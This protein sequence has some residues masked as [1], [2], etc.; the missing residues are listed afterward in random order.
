MSKH[1]QCSELHCQSLICRFQ[2]AGLL[3]PASALPG[4][5]FRP[6]RILLFIFLMVSASSLAHAANCAL[7]AGA[8]T[9]RVQAAVRAAA[10]DACT[11]TASE[12]TV[13][14]GEGSYSLKQIYVP[15][16]RSHLIFTGPVTK[17]PADSNARPTAVI[18][19]AYTDEGLPIFALATPC[20]TGATIEYLEVNGGRP[21]SGGGAVYLDKD[22][23]SHLK[24]LYNY[25]HGNQEIVPVVRG[26]VGRQYW[27]YDDTN[28]N[29]IRLDGFQSG[30][31][32]SDIVIE[33][34]I[35]GNP[36]PG[37]CSNVMKYIGGQIYA[38]GC[39]DAQGKPTLCFKGYDS[40]G[41][42]CSALT[43]LGNF[44][45]LYYEYNV[46]QQQEQGIKGVEGGNGVP[47]STLFVLVNTVFK[48]NDI[49][50]IHRA[51][52]ETQMSPTNSSQ[53]F[54]FSENDEHD[55]V[56]PAF[57]NW[58][59]SSPQLTYTVVTDN[60]M[61]TN[62]QKGGAEMPPGYE[63]WGNA[64]IS[65]NLSQGYNGCPI[66]FG[67]GVSPSASIQNNIL[68]SPSSPCSVTLA[69]GTKILGIQN[70]YPGAIKFDNFPKITGNTFS[71]RVNSFQSAAPSI[72]P[73]S[74]TFSGSQ[75]I[76]IIDNGNV[77]GAGPRG[78]TTIWYT[79]NG[80][81]PEPKSG[82]S[83]GCPSPCTFSVSTSTTIKA[84]GMWGA[85]TQPARYPAGYGFVPS[86]QVSATY[87][88]VPSGGRAAIAG[89]AARK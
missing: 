30:Q 61:V 50:F 45:D 58:G 72:S 48:Y 32:D 43:M 52:H 25:F 82:T 3:S 21:K 80:T 60:L 56:A 40:T 49:G 74:G 38:D 36:D 4:F 20:N 41:S 64:I 44:T 23:Y 7:T 79:T 53:P 2:G 77:S 70:E 9:S 16:G 17:Y 24:I 69:N 39:A 22:G 88:L 14:F 71:S 65:H 27:A 1:D 15:C 37:D 8:S 62:T 42:N 81:N 29:L 6:I 73:R 89:A 68:Q 13:T 66:E 34:N 55:P 63:W 31:T 86:A 57:T 10:R 59:L 11:G 51:F 78:N 83:T 85:I 87:T 76:T 35:E 19:S 33:Y 47:A 54:I 12:S 26:P 18:N 28:A 75:T 5:N 67:Y 46:I 84:I